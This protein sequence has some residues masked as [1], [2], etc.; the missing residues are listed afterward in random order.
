MACFAASIPEDGI[1]AVDVQTVGLLDALLDATATRPAFRPSVTMIVS[2]MGYTH[3]RPYTI[4]DPSY[5]RNAGICWQ[6]SAS[7][8]ASLPDEV[9]DS[10]VTALDVGAM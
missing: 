4:A 6:G 2:E 5:H 7:C 1:L 9:G 10:D 3:A 8:G